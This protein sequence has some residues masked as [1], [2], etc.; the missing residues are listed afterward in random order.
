MAGMSAWRANDVVEYDVM[1]ESATLLTGLLLRARS[2]NPSSSDVVNAEIE[3]IHSSVMEVDAYD[4]TAVLT[5]A[6]RFRGRI[7]TLKATS[8]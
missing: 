5:L 8:S 2:N 3:R 4:R 7:A 1:R 6:A